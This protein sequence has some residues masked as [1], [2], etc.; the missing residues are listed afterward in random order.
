MTLEGI[1]LLA[2]GAVCIGIIVWLF[3][4]RRSG[5]GD[6]ERDADR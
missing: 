2:A 1:V 4:L 6:S 5:R 3:W